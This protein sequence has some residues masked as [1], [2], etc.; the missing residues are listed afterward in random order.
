MAAWVMHRLA[1]KF[2]TVFRRTLAAPWHR[3][4]VAFAKV[5]TMIDMPIEVVGSVKPGSSPDEYTARKPLRAIVAIGSA[6][7]R[8]NLVISVGTNGWFPDADRNL[9]GRVWCRSH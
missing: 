1:V 8:G 4:A 3:P 7:I 9:R 5:K 2:G 6:V